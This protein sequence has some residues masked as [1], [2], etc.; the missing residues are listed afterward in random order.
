MKSVQSA[1]PFW[2]TVFQEF[3]NMTSNGL[4]VSN[5]LSV[6]PHSRSSQICLFTSVDMFI[7]QCWECCLSIVQCCF[8][9]HGWYPT[10]FK[11]VYWNEFV[12]DMA[13]FFISIIVRCK[14]ISGRT[15]RRTGLNSQTETWSYRNT[16]LITL[17]ASQLLFSFTLISF[18]LMAKEID[19]MVTSWG[20]MCVLYFATCTISQKGYPWLIS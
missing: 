15:F 16:K 11:A 14:H 18:V 1:N 2:E 8:N 13:R 12:E 7:Y 17:I 3:S 9:F 10:S 6:W 19:V 4:F 5:C 20:C